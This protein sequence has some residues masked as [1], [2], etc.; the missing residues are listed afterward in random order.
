METCCLSSAIAH[1]DEWQQMNMEQC[2]KANLGSLYRLPA[3][4]ITNC[5]FYTYLVDGRLAMMG[6]DWRLRTAAPTG[7]LFIPGWFAMWTVV[8][9]WLRLTTNLSTT[10]LWQPPRLSGGPVRRGISGSPQFYTYIH[11]CTCGLFNNALSSPG[12]IAL[13]GKWIMNWKGNVWLNSPT[14]VMLK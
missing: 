1:L 12:Y 3:R 14:D 6:W 13:D 9:Y 4:Q 2:K 8:R 5:S 7:L 10:A 11:I